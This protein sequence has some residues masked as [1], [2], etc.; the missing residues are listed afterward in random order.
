MAIR[1]SKIA[2]S[3]LLGL[4]YIFSAYS[5]LFPVEPFEYTF[6]DIG[7]S[8][9]KLSPFLARTVIGLEFFIG[10]LFLF[11][12]GVRSFTSKLSIGL[13]SFFSVYLVILLII[14]GNN[15]NCGCF[16]EMLPMTPLESILKNVLLIGIS[17]VLLKWGYE[18]NY[19]RA[20]K[21]VIIGLAL[22]AASY[23]YVRN[24]VDLNYSESYLQSKENRY[25]M[26]LDSLIKSATVNKVPEDLKKGKHVIAFLSSTCP[27]CKIAAIKLRIMKE[28]NPDLP[29]YFVINGLDEN[30]QRFREYTKCTNVP[31]TKLN[32][33]NFVYLAGL[34]LPTIVLVNDQQVEVDLTY[35]TLD[36]G[37]IESWLSVK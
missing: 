37:E 17:I 25:F 27:H 36:Q 20:K 29:L 9:W 26:P 11:Q 30:I 32:G 23:P 1:I 7:I 14:N 28:K 34:E 10:L 2:L 22:I 31:W 18:L 8:N 4:V 33:K 16:G 24:R 13:L 35:F 6:V 15:S 12:L 5:K 3:V 21:W 19:R